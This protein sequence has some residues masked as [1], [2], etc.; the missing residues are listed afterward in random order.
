MT[1]SAR[2]QGPP[3]G[4]DRLQSRVV[5]AALSEHPRIRLAVFDKG[6]QR[7]RTLDGE[8]YRLLA[9]PRTVASFEGARR[10]GAGP[11]ARILRGMS[12][13]RRVARARA[14]LEMGAYGWGGSTPMTVPLDAVAGVDF[15][16]LPGDVLVDLGAGWEYGIVDIARRLKAEQGIRYASMCH[17]IIPVMYPE[18]C[19]E[20]A[21][22]RLETHFRG[23]LAAADLILFHSKRV[24]GD[25]AQF[26]AD[27]GLTPAKS[28]FV[29]VGNDRLPVAGKS[30]LP[31]PLA[32]G[33]Y[34]L[35]VGTVEPRKGHR[36]LLDAWRRLRAEGLPAGQGFTLVFVGKPGWMVDDL[37]A[38]IRREESGGG[39]LRWLETVDDELLDRLYR[40]AAFCAVPSRY[41]GYGLAAIEAFA[42]GKP[43]LCSSGGALPEVV[44]GICDVID[45]IDTG[46]WTAAMRRFIA[47]PGALRVAEARI[48]AH[49][50]PLA[51]RDA[52]KTWLESLDSVR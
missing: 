23:L 42:Y 15:R 19:G 44:A 25:L 17:D 5:G 14:K 43:L 33:R 7:Y 13:G 32:P 36:V 52:V 35:A 26:A 37:V 31:A 6:R 8:A 29:P 11:L 1:I 12:A 39:A 16:F 30:D 4:I 24:A 27:R 47:D 41:E 38:E 51:W 48:R 3:S 21:R 34:A 22:A 9:D 10:S 2:W 49:F 50:K 46:A 28:C 45:P 40:D 18:W 20:G